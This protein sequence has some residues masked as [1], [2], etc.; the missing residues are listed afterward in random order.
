LKTG[1]T[2]Q[3]KGPYRMARV[4]KALYAMAKKM[5]VRFNKNPNFIRYHVVLLGDG[6]PEV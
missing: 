5:E 2:G 1:N 6:M 3:K 4:Q